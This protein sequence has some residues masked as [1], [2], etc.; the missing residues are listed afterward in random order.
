[1]KNDPEDISQLIFKRLQRNISEEEQEKLECW[2][3]ERQGRRRLVEELSDESAVRGHLELYLSFHPEKAWKKVDGSCVGRRIGFRSLFLRV[4]VIVLL[5]ATAGIYYFRRVEQ[6]AEV[7]VFSLND[8]H[9]GSN[10]AIL[11]LEDGQEVGLESDMESSRVIAGEYWKVEK[12]GQLS[13]EQKLQQKKWKNAWHT[14]RVPRGGEY[15]LK[16]E[17]GTMVWMNSESELKYPVHF[18]GNERRVILSG[19]A[20][21]KVTPDCSKA[22]IVETS[23]MEVRVFGTSF[24]VMAYQ[25]EKS[26]ATTLVEGS[27]KVSGK[28][29][30]E[31]EMMLQPGKQVLCVNGKLQVKEV[32]TDLYTAWMCGRFTFASEPLDMVLRK[33]ERWYDIRFQ[34]ENEHIRQRKFTGSVSR[35]SDITKILEMLELTTNIHF[36][37][38]GDQIVVEEN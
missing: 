34:L 19:Q 22:F 21:F 13:Y 16:L 6:E 12:E 24:D 1:M 20:F 28:N 3:Q 32:D 2:M 23:S 33:L 14:L 37:I 35:Y 5:F 8:V 18:A 30:T 36:S 17:D 4:A 29:G 31:G 27:V 38:R 26:F 10:Q 15:T 11:V 9:P 7:Q 25:D